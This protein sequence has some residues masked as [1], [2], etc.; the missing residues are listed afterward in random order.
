MKKVS[1]LLMAAAIL[2]SS[3]VQ[4]SA[5]ADVQIGNQGSREAKL[6]QSHNKKSVE[7][8]VEVKNESSII[9]RNSQNSDIFKKIGTIYSETT[10]RDNIV[11]LTNSNGEDVLASE[12]SKVSITI[13]NSFGKI[14]SPSD[15]NKAT[16][17]YFV[18]YRYN[19]AQA[20]VGIFVLPDNA[21]I[22]D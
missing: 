21:P 16:G 10:L 7:D 1:S 6:T 18:I 3:V 4:T 2:G 13:R 8:M 12:K 9:L 15:L 14:V 19:G 11:G 5:F 17:F 20:S 22:G